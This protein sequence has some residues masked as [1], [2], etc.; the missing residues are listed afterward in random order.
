MSKTRLYNIWIN[1]RQ[2][3][4]ND[5]KPAHDNWGN[6]GIT[7]CDEWQ[8]YKAFEEWAH[9]TGYADDLTIDRIDNNGNYG[10]S[11]CRWATYKEQ[12]NNTRKNRLITI[13]GE[14]RTFTE[15]CEHFH[16]TPSSVYKRIKGEGW[17]CEKAL[18]Y[19]CQKSKSLHPEKTEMLYDKKRKPLIAFNENEQIRFASCREAEKNG[20]CKGAIRKARIT[21]TKHHGYYWAFAET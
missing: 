7:V 1:M 18:S 13:G 17:S 14:T 4:K 10:P 6:R 8:S 12:A 2:R 20:H 15:W 5:G 21:G 19:P 11:N 3:C 16:I 9:N